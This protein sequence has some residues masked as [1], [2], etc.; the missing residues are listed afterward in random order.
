MKSKEDNQTTKK[1]VKAGAWYTVGNVLIKGLSFLT[2]PIFTR[3]MSTADYGLYTTYVAYESIMALVVSLGLH[4]SYKT[5]KVEFPGRIDSYVSSVSVLP[6]FFSLVFIVFLSP[7]SEAVSSLLGF[8]SVFVYIMIC[9]AL[10]SSIVTSYNCRIGLDFDYRSFIWISLILSVGNILLSILLILTINSDNPFEGRVI[11]TSLPV[12]LV[13]L[14]ILYKFFSASK[15]I[16][17]RK[18]FKFGISYSL[19]LIPHGLSQIILAQF[20]KII[21]QN[22]IGNSPAGIYGFAYTLALIPQIVMQSLGMAWGPWFFESYQQGKIDEIKTRSTQYVAFFSVFTVLL[23]CL[24]PELVKIMSSNDYW[25][26]INI[27]CPAILSVFFTFLYSL[28]AEIEYYYKKTT[29]IA[30]GT[31]TAAVLNIILCLI[32]VPAYGYAMAVYITIFTYV[33]YFIAHM[34]IAYFITDKKLPFEMSNLILYI[35]AVC[36]TMIIIQYFLNFICLRYLI[37]SLWV[38]IMFIRYRRILIPII[39]TKLANTK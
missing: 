21:I 2:L 35:L 20:G 31:I 36:L 4:A 12:I 27:V 38:G 3:L 6:L 9:Q 16:I 26:A 13:S 39:K 23:F 5:A 33:L 8:S 30:L 28:P 34:L 11:G 15:P 32:L 24:A 37:G 25:E 17:S 1:A 18:F 22:K 7:F 19:P 29:F 14:Y 10:G